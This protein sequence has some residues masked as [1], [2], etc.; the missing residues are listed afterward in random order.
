[1]DLMLKIRWGYYGTEW[2]SVAK[3]SAETM[4][5]LIFKDFLSCGAIPVKYRAVYPLCYGN[6][7]IYKML[8]Q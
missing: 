1:M 7:L 5:S 3:A 2:E 8:K 4:K 6:R